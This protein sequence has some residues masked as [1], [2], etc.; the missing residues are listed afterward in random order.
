MEKPWTVIEEFNSESPDSQL[1]VDS[2]HWFAR[3]VG[4]S[5]VLSSLL[6]FCLLP[7]PMY[8]LIA[9]PSAVPSTFRVPHYG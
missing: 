6:L 2:E 7:R 9:V 1:N 4:R 3:V 8:L 5:V